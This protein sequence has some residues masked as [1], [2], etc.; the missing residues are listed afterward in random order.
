MIVD[1]HHHLW[2]LSV[3]DQ[4]WITDPPMGVIRRSFL[5]PDFVAAAPEVSAS[6][7]VQ[8]VCVAEE[9]PEFLAIAASSGVV[10]AV[11]GW[12]DLTSPAVGDELAALVDRP[13]GS[14][15]R[16]IRHQ[17]QS[18]PDPEWLCRKDVWN[19]LAAVGAHGLVYELLTLPHQMPA[20]RRTVAALPQVEF[21]VDH[22]SK[23]A[24]GSDPG[25]WAELIR[26]LAAHENVTC[27]LSGLV[28]EADWKSW[29][30]AQLR[31]YFEVVLD[32]FG[33]ERL[34]FGSDWPVCLLAATY[35]E[36]LGAAR[37]LVSELSTGEQAE[38]F[39]GTARRVYAL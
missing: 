3:R 14:W 28:T 12:T 6:V 4:D 1:A 37:E 26:A 9:T 11:V 16:G 33:P 18:E 23:P 38:I 25:E 24:I 36:W 20:A 32:A 30:V 39:S 15:L 27:K 34:M 35:E 10:G 5:E 19:G 21:V 13:D 2:D 22:C 7:L 17:V 31:P 29:D 8:T